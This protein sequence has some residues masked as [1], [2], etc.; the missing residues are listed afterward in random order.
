LFVLANSMNV[1][2]KIV[3]VELRSDKSFEA[4]WCCHYS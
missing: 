4:G 3:V 2:D 1:L